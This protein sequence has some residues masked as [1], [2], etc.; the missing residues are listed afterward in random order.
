MSRTPM[1]LQ[2][3]LPTAIADR[4]PGPTNKPDVFVFV[5]LLG[6][7]L[8]CFVVSAHLVIAALHLAHITFP[9]LLTLKITFVCSVVV[10]AASRIGRELA[11]TTWGCGDDY[12]GVNSPAGSEEVFELGVGREVKSF[13]SFS[14]GQIIV[15]P[16]MHVPFIVAVCRGDYLKNNSCS[17]GTEK[18]K[19]EVWYFLSRTLVGTGYA[20]SAS[21]NVE[22]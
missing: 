12:D 4:D 20:Y 14:V 9:V 3:E 10:L 5:P 1:K 7:L 13:A 8:L 17:S 16:L 2:L 22:T 19:S 21:L 18:V 6:D 15:A 11:K